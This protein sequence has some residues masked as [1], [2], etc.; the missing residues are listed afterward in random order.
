MLLE[1]YRTIVLFY[2]FELYIFPGLKNAQLHTVVA[3]LV[4][5]FLFN[6]KPKP[7]KLA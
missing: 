6:E 5:H 7:E 2:F 1:S 3:L 4:R